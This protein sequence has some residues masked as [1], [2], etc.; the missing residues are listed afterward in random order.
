MA[1]ELSTN[2]EGKVEM[3]SGNGIIPWHKLGTVVQGMLKAEEA[4]QAA[5]LNWNVERLPLHTITGDGTTIPVPNRFALAREDNHRVL[6]V[7]K[8]KYN[9]IQNQEAFTFFD[10]VVGEGQAVYDTA[11]A[12][13]GGAMI[14]ILAKLKDSLFLERK[15]GIDQTDRYVLLVKGHDA[16]CP[17]TIQ[18]VAIRVVCNNTLQAALKGARNK[19]SIR[20]TKGYEGHMEEAQRVL[21]LIDGYYSRLD[22]VLKKLDQMPVTSKNLTELVDKIFPS[23]RMSTGQVVTYEGAREAVKGLFREGTGNF[24]ETR[25]DLLNAVTEYVDHRRTTRGSKGQ[26][27]SLI[28]RAQSSYFGG[29]LPI[30]KRAM[31]VLAGSLSLN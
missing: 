12:I 25:Y 15:S 16:N 2:A 31:Q 1:H 9:V 17:L 14:W 28:S 8:G 5:S 29:G 13:R 22:L 18:T 10:K 7:C 24:G 3:F 4:L 23:T 30:K 11:G 6:G 26:D 21:G 20:H 19:I 27:A